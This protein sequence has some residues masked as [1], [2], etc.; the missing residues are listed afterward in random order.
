MCKYSQYQ[1]KKYHVLHIL[2]LL[3]A[4]CSG[5]LRWRQKTEKSPANRWGYWLSKKW[6]FSHTTIPPLLVRSSVFGVVDKEWEGAKPH[7]PQPS[8]GSQRRNEWCSDKGQSKEGRPN[9]KTR[10]RECAWR[11]LPEQENVLIQIHFLLLLLCCV[12]YVFFFA[13]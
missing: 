6:I 11:C 7:S 13:E 8:A 4:A 5:R 1:S 3:K 9:R 2:V 12:I 10:K